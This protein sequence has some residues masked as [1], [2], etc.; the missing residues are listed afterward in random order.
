VIM[1][2]KKIFTIICF[3]FASHS[4]AK[5][6]TVFKNPE[7]IWGLSKLNKKT[8]LF[9]E[10]KGSVFTFDLITKKK[11]KLLISF[12]GLDTK[13]QGGL[14]D[15]LYYEQKIYFTYV[16]KK[17]DKTTTRL[18]RVVFKNN[19]ATKFEVLFTADAFESTRHH[20]GSR[21]H[22]FNN[23]IF[24]TIGDRG[25][26]DKAQSLLSH[27]G[28]IVRLN[29]D[30]SIPKDNPFKESAIFTLGHR[31]S[32]GISRYKAYLYN[33]E[34]GP[35][36]GDEINLLKA[37][38][39]YGWP[40]YTYGE[41]YGSGKIETKL[42]KNFKK[43]YIMPNKYWVP[44][45]SF[46]DIIFKENY[47][48]LACLGTKQIVRLSLLDDK[49]SDEVKVSGNLS[50]RFRTLEVLNDRIYFATDEGTIGFIQ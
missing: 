27:H 44:S 7:S 18:A 42:K 23:K 40:L 22:I 15:L 11:E 1:I 8:L 32:Q 35:Q 21:L 49:I 45:L 43:N 13:G 2:S 46:S 41:E 20:Y 25:K 29:L 28:K 5:T 39:N 19:V 30:G 37:G 10:K 47:L 4:L 33:G 50:E 17:N 16:F 6:T 36:G 24:M 26:R 38:G 31:N 12:P 9:T 14:L 3:I 48:Y 34:F